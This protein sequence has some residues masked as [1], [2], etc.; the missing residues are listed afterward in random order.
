MLD[1]QSDAKESSE[2]EES[3]DSESEEESNEESG[4][5]TSNSDDS[6]WK[7]WINNDFLTLTVSLLKMLETQSDGEESSEKEES[8]ESES[9]VESNEEYGSSTLNSDDS[10]WKLN[11]FA[12]LILNQK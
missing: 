2:E 12:F 3:N 1:T 11:K 8:N 6:D 5:S 10:Y 4:S 9:E 7:L